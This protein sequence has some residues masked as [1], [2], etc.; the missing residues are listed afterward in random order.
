MGK[1]KVS[2]VKKPEDFNIEEAIALVSSSSTGGIVIFLGKVRDENLGRK[3][4]KLIYEA[5]DEMAIKE[6][7][8]I[9]NEALDRFPIV[10]ALIWHRIGELEVGENTI[11]VVVSAKHRR[12]AFEACAWIVDE[13]KKR[14]PVWKR[15]VT[16]E[17]EFWIEGDRHVPVKR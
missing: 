3:V 14:V 15:E 6:M 4:E 10:D 2:L 12:E 8:R 5:Y 17:G 9:R 13:V 7:E 1:S 16:D 11:L